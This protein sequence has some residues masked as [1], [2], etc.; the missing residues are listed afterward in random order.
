MALARKVCIYYLQMW[1]LVRHMTFFFF[2]SVQRLRWSLQIRQKYQWSIQDR[3]RRFGR[4]WS[5][6]WSQNSGRRLD[7]LS[8]TTRRLR[9]FLSQLGC[10]QKGLWQCERRILA[11]AG[12]DSPPDSERQYQAS[13]GL[14]RH[15]REYSFRRIQFL[16]C[17]KRAGKISAESG[18]LFRCLRNI[19]WQPY[20]IVDRNSLLWQSIKRVQ[21]YIFFIYRF[22]RS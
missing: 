18:E 20:T 7:G 13:R 15:S 11:W 3:S 21:P 19:Y 4:F 10:L 5:V 1:V 17:G 6:L 22:R 12:Q 2:H 8:K 14:G 9:R 16:C